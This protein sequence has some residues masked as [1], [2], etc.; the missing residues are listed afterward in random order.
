M[1]AKHFVDLVQLVCKPVN[2]RSQV[3][4][5]FFHFLFVAQ[6]NKNK[7]D[8]RVLLYSDPLSSRLLPAHEQHQPTGT[9]PV[10]MLTRIRLGSHQRLLVSLLGLN[11]RH[12]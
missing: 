12:V 4:P 9:G 3:V 7:A 5:Q 1:L 6:P 10:I 8:N 11:W 2:P